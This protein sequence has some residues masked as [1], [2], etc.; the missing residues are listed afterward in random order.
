MKNGSKRINENIDK[1]SNYGLVIF[2]HFEAMEPEW[3]SM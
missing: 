2:W 1:V 3:H